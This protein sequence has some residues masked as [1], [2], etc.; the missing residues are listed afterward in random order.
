MSDPAPEPTATAI[1]VLRF[2]R[3]WSGAQPRW[4]GR[5]QHV[6]SGEEMNFIGTDGLLLFLERFGIRVSAQTGRN[7]G[8]RLDTR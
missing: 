5:V 3:E 6:Q 7:E 1:F 8:E 2:W 4:R